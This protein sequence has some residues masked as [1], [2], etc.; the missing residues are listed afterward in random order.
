LDGEK[1]FLSVPLTFISAGQYPVLDTSTGSLALTLIFRQVSAPEKLEFDFNL[2]KTNSPSLPSVIDG[3][4]NRFASDNISAIVVS[5]PENL[6]QINFK[7]GG[8]IKDA[9]ITLVSNV[10]NKRTYKINYR[11]FVWAYLQ[12][13]FNNPEWFDGIETLGCINRIRMYSEY[14]NPNSVMTSVSQ[15]TNGNIGA[16]GENYNTGNEEYTLDNVIFADVDDNV[17][18]GINYCGET[19]FTAIIDAPTGQLDVTNS[20]FNLG[21]TWMPIDES[22]YQNKLNSLGANLGLS[23]P[24]IDFSHSVTPSPT[25]YNGYNNPDLDFSW[26]FKDLQFEIVGNTFVATGV[27]FPTTNNEYFDTLGTGEKRHI[28]WVSSKRLD[29]VQNLDLKTSVELYDNDV[30]CAPVLGEQI[31]IKEYSLKDHA[32]IE[33][34]DITTE[35]DSRIRLEVFLKDDVV[36][37]D[38]K[39]GFQMYNTVTGEHFNLEQFTFNYDNF[40]FINGAYQMNESI[41]RNFNL[42]PTSN[43]NDINY[44]STTFADT[45]PNH[46]RT[47]L[48]YGFLSDWRYWMNKLNVDNDFFDLTQPNNGYNKNW[49]HYNNGDWTF[50]FE[51]LLTSDGVSDFYYENIPIRPYEDE[52]VTKTTTLID[53]NDNSVPIT[54]IA[55]TEIEETTQLVWNLG[56]YDFASVW[57]EVTIE[58]YESGNRWVLSSVLEQGGISS[59]PLK[60]VIPSDKL[61]LQIYGNLAQLRFKVDTSI[62]DVDKVSM[63]YR[64][65]SETS[66]LAQWIDLREGGDVMTIGTSP[67]DDIQHDLKMTV[68]RTPDGMV[69]T[70][71]TVQTFGSWA[72]FNY[73]GFTRASNTKMSY[74]MLVDDTDLNEFMIGITSELSSTL[75]DQSEQLES[76]VY[77][78]STKIFSSIVGN[79]GT[80]GTPVYQIFDNV[81]QTTGAYK[82]VIDGSGSAGA[83]FKLYKL[84]NT[85]VFSWN[86]ESNLLY[87]EASIL[88]P[89]DIDLLPMFTFN[90]DTFTIVAINNI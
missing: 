28:F 72:R 63:S 67:S 82:V 47:V 20:R 66:K 15:N 37:E 45:E 69:C 80:L 56:N 65:S 36:Y 75:G 81:I 48:E 89:D 35:D 9:T 39:A 41:P 53:L 76:S 26:S 58:D 74:I 34:T 40:A 61:E 70:P 84:P 30:I 42:P 19:K 60:S 3:E 77:M 87:S 78:N 11:F 85:S 29:I 1:M 22:A 18:Q 12:S 88:T 52:D 59:N 46:Y 57:A 8:L 83:M 50:R 71:E 16:F 14:N 62:I 27:I 79:N 86:D 25:I 17:I 73:L 54:L 5:T 6:N 64:I 38:L 33:V 13:G 10:D 49:Q 43:K 23:A 44:Y 55:N 51:I 31:L 7:S 24:D 2:T 68:L 21:L 4:I 90:N 32:E